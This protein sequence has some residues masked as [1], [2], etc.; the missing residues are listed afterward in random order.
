MNVETTLRDRSVL[1]VED[2]FIVAVGLENTFRKA[3]VSDVTV[4]GNMADA[5]DAISNAKF[6]FALLDIRLP[7]GYSFPLAMNLMAQDVPVV[8]HSGHAEIYH[9]ARLPG[10]IFCPKPA[11][12]AEIVRA[13]MK[14]IQFNG[15]SKSAYLQDTLH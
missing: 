13:S 5:W 4:I 9:S 7:D 15:V 12:P 14:A 1:I 2:E 3:G 11:T 10:I 8:I 6:D